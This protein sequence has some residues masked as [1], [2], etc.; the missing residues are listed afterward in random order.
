MEI[1]KSTRQ[2]IW[3]LARFTLVALLI[4]VPIRLYIAQPFL[5]VGDSMV[6]TFHNH[7][8]LVIDQLSYRF[9][10]PKRGDVVVFK[11]PYDTKRY[12]IKRL[13]GLPGETVVIKDSEVRIQN[14]EYPNGF[15]LT[16]PYISAEVFTSGVTQLGNGEYF[17]M[18]D[19]RTYSSGSRAWGVLGKEFL[20]GRAL[21]RLWPISGIDLFPGVH[22]S[23]NDHSTTS[24]K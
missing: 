7:D 21:L 13:I 1:K 18:G 8:Y 24:S 20:T 6:P 22:A 5:V 2:E 17:V 15:V 11:Y 19:N 16:E 14:D 23:Y 9:S 3:E 4:V 12:F 10:E